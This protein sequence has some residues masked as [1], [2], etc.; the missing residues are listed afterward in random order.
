MQAN[1]FH[2][3]IDEA[4]TPIGERVKALRLDR[5]LTLS[6]VGGA[7][8]CLHVELVKDRTRRRVAVI[9][10]RHAHL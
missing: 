2:T 9:R 5:G 6:E 8:V 10:Y 3:S 4:A 1:D 7:C